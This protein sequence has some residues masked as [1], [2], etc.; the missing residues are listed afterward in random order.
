MTHEQLKTYESQLMPCP[1]CGGKA[2][3]QIYYGRYR[4]RC[5]QSVPTCMTPVKTMGYL[6]PE[7]AIKA[8]NTRSAESK[9]LENIRAEI[10]ESYRSAIIENISYAEGLERAWVIIDKH[11]EGANK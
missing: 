7:E 9:V 8:W 4:V 6:T 2:E 5:W 1:F 10:E 3:L 11:I